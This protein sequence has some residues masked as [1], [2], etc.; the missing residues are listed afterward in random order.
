MKYQL[1]INGEACDARNGAIL[2][3]ENPATGEIIDTVP[4][5]GCDDV[6]M[7]ISSAKQAF[8]D[9]RWSKKTP[10]E[11]AAILAK[12]ADLIEA[13]SEEFA[14]IE[15]EDTGKPYNLVSMGSDIP[16]A[17]DNLRFFASA[18]RNMRG[19][20]S[21]EYTTGYSSILRKEPCGV[22]VGIAPWNYPFLMAIW[23]IGPALA[24]GCCSILK[25]APTTPR[26][27]LL[28][29]A[30][31]KEAGLPDG[32]LN[33]LSGDNETGALLTA[34]PDVQMISLTGSCRTG[35]AIMKSAADTLKR[36]HLELGGKA[37]LII[38]D[39]ADIK[40][41]AEKATIGGF[42]NSGQDC[43]AATRI[44]VHESIYAKTVDALVQATKDFTIGSP[45]DADTKI[46]SMISHSQQQTVAGFVERAQQAGA[47][48]LIGGYIPERSGYYYAP[49]LLANVKQDSEVVQEEIFGPVMTIQS[50]KTDDEA[51][52]MAN[53]VKYGLA[54][55][56]FTK[57]I[58]RA[59]RFS[60]ELMFGTVWINDHLPLSSETPHG[61]FKQS[62]FGKD[63]SAEAINDYLVT[64]H[65]MVSL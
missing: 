58:N 64:K 28:L 19:S 45:F 54:S 26:T 43:T 35:K 18:T 25:P 4:N 47:T 8:E 7:A 10:G 29:G 59:M 3:V 24:A 48:V 32:V 56:V 44:L 50:F 52:T 22:A 15:S 30:I 42:L 39:D 9:G 63:L 5:A 23:K 37:P 31:A 33:I 12:M 51:L 16:F 11:R 36:V 6:N 49:T 17:I 53:D 27:S 13:R 55:S 62:G 21:A 57:D 20:A 1:W 41:A 34:H 40:K 2:S 46:G 60:R 14:R 61:G 38:F 65:V